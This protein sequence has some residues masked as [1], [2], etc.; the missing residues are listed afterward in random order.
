MVSIFTIKQ[1]RIDKDHDA[2]TS[3]DIRPQLNSAG[4]SLAGVTQ[5]SGRRHK[6]TV[7][8]WVAIFLVLI[9]LLF[10]LALDTARVL[11]VAHQL[12]NAADAAAL[13]GAR[14]V[15]IDQLG[16]R[17]QA[18]AIAFGNYADG[19][20]VQLADNFDNLPD[21]DIVVGRYDRKTQV[22]TVTTLAPNALRI[23]ARR[24]ANSLGGPIP[25]NF[26]PIVNVK[27]SNIQ[28]YTVAMASGG[29]GAG[30]IA[31]APEG[32]GLK[33]NG[34]VTLHVNDGAIQVNSQD[35][36]GMKVI[37]QPQIQASE[38]NVTGDVDP[39]GG[40]SFDPDLPV[41]TGASPIDDPLCPNPPVDCLPAPLWNPAN[42]LAPSPGET[43]EISS[44]T[45]T[46]EPGFYSG[47]LNMTGGDVILKPGIYIL[48]GGVTGKGG[49]VIGGNTNLCAKGV[50]FF[51]T[52]SGKV[53]IAGTGTIRATPMKF[54][55][56]DFCDDTFAYPA[57]VYNFPFYEDTVIFQD[58]DNTTDARIVGTGLLDLDGTL[59]FPANHVDLT[60]TGDGFGQQLIAST[61]E[62]SGTGEISINYDGRNRTSANRSFIV[63]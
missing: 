5:G 17:Q 35:D 39:T 44:G 15:K 32:T 34:D 13:A 58:R 53:D 4:C 18:A 22:F 31:L 45:A 27:N 37:G 11:L 26:G 24:T 33:I 42:D 51:V 1:D 14:L 6:G 41:N 20:F 10:G 49:L 52:G 9:I 16:A 29:T 59:Y 40:F 19:K 23:V 8:I 25:L 7:I 21:G 57:D 46:L 12:Q 38:L 28:R 3:Y 54:D 2:R 48:D 60:G 56:S 47:G 30:L 61:I 43:Y 50:M 63:E 36:Q 62:I 55:E